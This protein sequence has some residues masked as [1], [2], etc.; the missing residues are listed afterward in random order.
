MTL[1]L[2]KDNS[3]Q[4]QKT[5]KHQPPT[6]VWQ[7]SG[8]SAKF[9]HWNSNEHGK[10]IFISQTQVF[11][12]YFQAE[13]FRGEMDKTKLDKL[14]AEEKLSTFLAQ[15][16]LCGKVGISEATKIFE[17]QKSKV[18]LSTNIQKNTVI[19]QAKNYKSEIIFSKF[20]DF[21]NH[22]QNQLQIDG[23]FT[24]L[25]KALEFN[26][27]KALIKTSLSENNFEGKNL[28]KLN[29]FRKKFKSIEFRF[30]PEGR[31]A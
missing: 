15:S 28:E 25:Q 23:I 12:S 20:V 17:E 2:K 24:L 4:T 19:L 30:V 13:L 11:L 1:Q 6:L 10:L 14:V 21:G 8:F 29:N 27:K 9:E 26:F 22:E 16:V 31:T 18:I 7:K 5:K 3:L